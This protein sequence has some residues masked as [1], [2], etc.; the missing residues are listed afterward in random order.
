MTQKI[1]T[2]FILQNF[3]ES[4]DLSKRHGLILNQIK[5]NIVAKES[6]DDDEC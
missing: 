4:F 3:I 6:I 5:I 1:N 2:L